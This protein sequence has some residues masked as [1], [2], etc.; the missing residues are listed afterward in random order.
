MHNVCIIYSGRLDRFYTGEA[1]DVGERVKQHNDGFFKN[2]FTSSV[3]DWVLF[4]IIDCD[5]RIQARKI[6]T[7]IKKM[8]SSKYIRDIKQYPDIIFKLKKRYS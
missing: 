7:H 3:S 4:A 1:E 8:K 2:S 6:E 5:Y